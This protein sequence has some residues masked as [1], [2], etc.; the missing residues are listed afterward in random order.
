MDPYLHTIVA[1]GLMA[2]CYYAGKYFGKQEGVIHVWTALLDAFQAREIIIDEE[3]LI[4][5][6]YDDGSEKTLN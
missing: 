1:V 3:G 6:T 4:T 2:A 5:I